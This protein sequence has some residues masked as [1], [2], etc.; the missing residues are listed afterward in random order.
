[1]LTVTLLLGTLW[2]VVLV[3][4]AIALRVMASSDVACGTGLGES[5]TSHRFVLRCDTCKSDGC[6]SH[7][8]S[9]E[10]RG[11][12][13]GGRTRTEGVP[14]HGAEENIWIPEG[15][16]D[17]TLGENWIIRILIIC[18]H[19]QIWSRN[20]VVDIASILRN[21]RSGDRI[22][23]GKNIFLSSKSSRPTM[24]ATQTPY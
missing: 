22:P 11:S 7:R 1:M 23:T 18:S 2:A 5:S 15:E 21:G 24:G 8:H 3:S 16:N 6:V 4:D 10:R 17:R 19:L 9:A 20:N 13:R 14:E 12:W